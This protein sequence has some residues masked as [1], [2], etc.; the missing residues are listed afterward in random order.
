MPVSSTVFR[1]G[2]RLQKSLAVKEKRTEKSSNHIN[3]VWTLKFKSL[4]L[5]IFV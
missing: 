3:L 5:I 2:V 1:T 4:N